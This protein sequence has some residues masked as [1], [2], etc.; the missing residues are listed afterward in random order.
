MH[1]PIVVSGVWIFVYITLNVGLMLL[2]IK[3]EIKICE[4]K[5]YIKELQDVKDLEDDIYDNYLYFMNK[6]NKI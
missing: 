2:L 5:T 4:Q 6:I 3:V 1:T